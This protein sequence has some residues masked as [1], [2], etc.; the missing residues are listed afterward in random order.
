MRL[1][2]LRAFTLLAL[3]LPALAACG[4]PKDRA[5]EPIQPPP[6][7]KV[8][9]NGRIYT[10]DSERR[11]VD[12]MAVAGDAIASVGAAADM[13]A[14]KGP[15]A[16]VIDLEGRLVLPGLHDAHLHPIG[17]MPVRSC[18]LDNTPST[19]EEIADYAKE[20]TSQED[21]ADDNWLVVVLWNFAAGNQ[22]G[23]KYQTIRQALDAVSKRKPVIL[24][25]SDGH[26]FA[27]NS[28]AL[29]RAVNAQG[30]RVGFSKATLESDFAELAPYIGVDETGKPNGRLTEDYALAA[31]GAGSFM[32]T[33]IEKRREAPEL[34]MTMTLPRGITS[35]LDAAADPA[36]LDIYDKLLARGEFHA[37]AHLALYLDP[38]DYADE[39]GTINYDALLAEAQAIRAKYRDEPLVEADFLK[40]FADGVMEGDPLA[41]PPMLPNSAFSRNYLQPVFKWD[42]ET[43]WVIVADYV[44]P[45]SALCVET[46]ERIAAG[47]DINAAAFR[48]ANGFHP[49]QCAEANGV[50]QHP[51]Q[52]IMDYVREGDAAGFTF[53]IHA[54]G[55]RTVKV[56]LDAI[57]AAREANGEEQAHIVTHL[58]VVRPEDRARFA[59]NNVFASFTFAWA[60]VDPQY[61]TTVI[62]FVDRADGANGIYDPQGYYY[63]NVYP[64][65]SIR[66][67]G[68]VI[69]AGSDAPVD[70]ADPRPFVNIEGAV[71]RSIFGHAPL[72]RNEAIS[73]FDAVDAYTIN[74]ARALK[75]DAIAG[76]LEPGKKADFIVLDRDIFEIADTGYATDISETKVLETWFGGNLV[77]SL[78]Q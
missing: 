46:R 56:A 24:R 61:D 76:S 67:A 54:I 78:P 35:F 69:I 6:V 57:E 26:H 52:T 71:S 42:E 32:E 65:E 39:A 4:A 12:A 33:G 3:S 77:Y 68:G 20:C 59:R 63:R 64:A 14:L 13:E 60:T 66:R 7:D 28:V 51:E 2:K 22:P 47:A 72:N 41:D 40:L 31:I 1:N 9:V 5:D 15:H 55:D 58:Q 23:E 16:Q 75:Q 21:M 27:V 34:M 36:T 48:S 53:H 73:I 62:P 25:G 50:L 11:F 44:D 37:R 30:K 29:A 45:A 74:A 49:L 17:A 18:S 10:A 43:Q 70:T 38:G 19:L 8:F